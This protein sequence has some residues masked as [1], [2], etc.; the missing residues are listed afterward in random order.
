ML[1]TITGSLLAIAVT[2]WVGA[3]SAS[4][5]NSNGANNSFATAQNIDPFFSLDFDVR[6][7]DENLVNT[8]TSIHHVEISAVGDDT[9]D[10]YSFNVGADGMLA[11]FDIDCGWSDFGNFPTPPECGAPIENLFDSYITLYDSLEN[12]VGFNDDRGFPS[13]PSGND[14]GSAITLDSF[15]QGTL[16]AGLYFLKVSEFGGR[17]IQDD[18]SYVLNV[19]LQQPRVPQVP[20]PGILALFGLGLAGLGFS[21]RK[22]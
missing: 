3:A 12:V 6:I 2:G 4:P 8:S 16:S 18:Q 1:K 11:I 13:S 15:L 10:Y 9:F 5:I 20:A 19:S 7:E 17:E 21:R 22:R 14:T